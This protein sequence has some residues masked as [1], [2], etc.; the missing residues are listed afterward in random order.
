[1]KSFSAGAVAI[2]V[3]RKSAPIARPKKQNS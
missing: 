1:M 3:L 2:I